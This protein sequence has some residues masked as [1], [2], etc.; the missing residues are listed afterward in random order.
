MKTFELATT[1]T[2]IVRSV[3]MR[4]PAQHPR[5]HCEPVRPWRRNR[6]F[7]DS[8]CVPGVIALV[9]TPRLRRAYNPIDAVLDLKN[10]FGRSKVADYFSVLSVTYLRCKDTEKKLVR[11]RRANLRQVLRA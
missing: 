7:C 1:I 2:A 9:D 5:R 6:T 4:T 11:F 8:H 10:K 3:H